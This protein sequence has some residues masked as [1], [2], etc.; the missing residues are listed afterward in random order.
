MTDFLLES[1]I[2]D[3]TDAIINRTETN[4]PK[5]K[6]YTVSTKEVQSLITAAR[7]NH[8][9]AT[10]KITS[11]LVNLETEINLSTACFYERCITFDG[12][13]CFP[14]GSIY[15]PENHQLSLKTDSDL[16]ECILYL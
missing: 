9:Y 5:E 11:D 8:T 14:D 16:I 6:P 4:E 13:E 15:D 7:E 12:F 2:Q 1:L 10:L 3:V